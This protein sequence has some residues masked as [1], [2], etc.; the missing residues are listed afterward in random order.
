MSTGL[1]RVGVPSRVIVITRAR[2]MVPI[3]YCW[4]MVIVC[5]RAVVVI[6]V[7]VACVLV[8]VQRRRHGRRDD[9]GLNEHECDDTAH[10]NSLLRP[11]NGLRAVRDAREDVATIGA[12]GVSMAYVVGIMLSLSVAPFASSL[13]RYALSPHVR[14]VSKILERWESGLSPIEQSDRAF[15]CR[16]TFSTCVALAKRPL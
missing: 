14:S 4:M 8:D 15:R 10:G 13:V 2:V 9:Q 6:R 12:Q 16:G 5:R 1:T 11:R 3:S 7:I